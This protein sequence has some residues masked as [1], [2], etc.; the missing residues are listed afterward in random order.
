M[1][2]A[3]DG[4]LGRVAGVAQGG[5]GRRF[6]EALRAWPSAASGELAA[7]CFGGVCVESSS[8][9]MLAAFGGMC[10]SGGAAARARGVVGGGMRDHERV[11]VGLVRVRRVVVQRV[12]LAVGRVVE[13]GCRCGAHHDHTASFF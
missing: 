6:F 2:G 3:A 5:A 4:C 11:V 8:L 7:V 13:R 12:R 1:A 10:S 9:A